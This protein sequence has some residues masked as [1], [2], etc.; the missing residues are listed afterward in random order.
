MRNAR[1]IVNS[2]LETE[3]PEDIDWSVD[4]DDPDPIGP[5]NVP[6]KYA[7]SKRAD[8][9]YS[10]NMPR[11]G[12]EPLL[13][14]RRY[15]DKAKPHG[16]GYTQRTGWYR[17]GPYSN[18]LGPTHFTLP[19]GA[20][21][22]KLDGRTFVVFWPDG[23]IGIQLHGTVIIKRNADGSYVANTGGYK[24]V[25]TMSRLA[26][27]LPFGWNL[28]AKYPKSGQH[29]FYWFNRSTGVGREDDRTIRFSDGDRIQSDGMLV[30]KAATV[31]RRVR[32]K[33]DEP[34]T[35]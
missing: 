26:P 29:D 7:G 8:A 25:T 13:K 35:Q 22:H 24:T 16:G 34:T 18:N 31:Y 3:S 1:A 32:K 19:H 28:Y 14:M 5:T 17:P 21:I 20:R 30:P 27:Y 4:P 6:M 10:P 9:D 33:R 15:S 23:A 2:L 11:D 12:D